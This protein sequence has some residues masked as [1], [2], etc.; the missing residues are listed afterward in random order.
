MQLDFLYASPLHWGSL[1][2]NSLDI[3]SELQALRG[4]LGISPRIEVATMESL[5]DALLRKAELPTVL[6][7]SAHIGTPMLPLKPQLLLED[8]RGVA[9]ALCEDALAALASWEA[10]AASGASWLFVF[11]ACGSKQMVE[12]LMQSAGLR[13]AICCAGDVLD[14]A[15]RVFCRAFYKALA[16]GK[17]V[18]ESHAVA[19]ASVRHSANL[20]IRHESEKFLYL[21]KSEIDTPVDIDRIT[22]VK[23]APWI[24]WPLWPRVEDY[25]ACRLI[26]SCRIAN[27]FK[28]RRVVLVLGDQGIGKSAMCREFCAY[29][30]APGRL[31][32]DRALLLDETSFCTTNEVD[33]S[34]HV[35][36]IICSKLSE[37]LASTADP[38]SPMPT[39]V[40]QLVKSMDQLGL[41]LLAVDGLSEMSHLSQELIAQLDAMLRSSSSM[42]LLLTS[43][44]R[45]P[46]IAETVGFSGFRAAKEAVELPVSPLPPAAAAKLFLRRAKRPFFPGDF[47]RAAVGAVSQPLQYEPQILERL[48]ASPLLHALGGV[49]G[50]IA[51]AAM[52]VNSSLPSLL[53][54]PA[55]PADWNLGPGEDVETALQ[56]QPVQS[57]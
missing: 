2:L 39:D 50:L 42:K 1:P 34:T 41:W 19:Q 48:A 33:K 55:L 8:Q 3:M 17:S 54:H 13:H 28:D 26:D 36:S 46:L 31:F 4:I 35:A 37:Q 12:H 11:L 51:D 9:H 49:P 43:R 30:S 7:L 56:L 15:A 22:R 14:A 40:L 32:S 27:A 24:S 10:E 25:A 29:F 57:D 5:Q 45:V 6:H 23:T 44:H 20:G 16:A 53:Q 21:V 38:I 52:L 18:V 47:D